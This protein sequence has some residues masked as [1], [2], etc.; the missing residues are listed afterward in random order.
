MTTSTIL[1]NLVPIKFKVQN[2][3]SSFDK[4]NNVK[5]IQNTIPALLVQSECE[6][7]DAQYATDNADIANYGISCRDE[8]SFTG[9]TTNWFAPSID[10][11]KSTSA[12]RALI[13]Q[14]AYYI[15]AHE[16]GEVQIT[17]TPD[18]KTTAGGTKYVI[19]TFDLLDDQWKSRA[20]ELVGFGKDD[21]QSETSS[22]S[23]SDERE[24]KKILAKPICSTPG[25]PIQQSAGGKSQS[26][27]FE[28]G[29]N[30]PLGRPIILET[31]YQTEHE[32]AITAVS[33]WNEGEVIIEARGPINK[34]G[35]WDL[36]EV[37][38]HQKVEE[39]V[40]GNSSE[41]QIEEAETKGK[42]DSLTDFFDEYEDM[43]KSNFIDDS[44]Q[45]NDL[46]MT[47]KQKT[48]KPRL[49]Q[50]QG[51]MQ[52]VIEESEDSD[53][54][55][56]PYQAAKRRVKNTKKKV[57]VGHARQRRRGE[58]EDE[59]PAFKCSKP[60]PHDDMWSYIYRVASD[61][62]DHRIFYRL[63]AE[64]VDVPGVARVMLK[65][66]TDFGLVTSNMRGLR[67]AASS[68]TSFQNFVTNLV[69]L[70][71]TIGTITNQLNQLRF[72]PD[73]DDIYSFLFKLFAYMR[74]TYDYNSNDEIP[75][76][77]II[78]HVSLAFSNNIQL[79][80]FF[81][82]V[83]K[84]QLLNTPNFELDVMADIIRSYLD[85][86]A[87]FQRSQPKKKNVNSMEMFVRNANHL[88]EHPTG[89]SN[90]HEQD[91]DQ[92]STTKKRKAKK[93]K[94]KPDKRSQD[95]DSS[96]N[97][98]SQN[99]DKLQDT[100]DKFMEMQI[101]NQKQYINELRL[102]TEDKNNQKWHDSLRQII[103][104]RNQSQNVP[105]FAT[106]TQQ[107]QLHE[108]NPGPH[109]RDE[110]F[111]PRERIEFKRE[112]RSYWIYAVKKNL[113]FYKEI[114]RTL[115]RLNAG[116]LRD[117]ICKTCYGAH[118]SIDHPFRSQRKR[119]ER[120]QFT[121]NDAKLLDDFGREIR[122]IVAELEAG[123]LN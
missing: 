96:R 110:A 87:I 27:R 28:N 50:K 97:T 40:D 57:N 62:S 64:E 38:T 77:K 121:Q 12:I 68:A 6:K 20:I 71:G 41:E 113:A 65:N 10:I 4:Y 66:M 98:I 1:I 9:I 115:Q 47:R 116:S 25:R 107:S 18:G 84:F 55:A 94:A 102:Q 51:R 23:S 74:I 101:S 29:L 16:K 7:Y 43:N 95:N 60:S 31:G 53:K 13:Q 11:K 122:Q 80:R 24:S 54:D 70:T 105:V 118:K 78:H 42:N 8:D 34:K 17:V 45:V 5:K 75:K 111:Y 58:V 103:D 72:E 91:S 2:Y 106:M 92:S 86:Q 56:G 89:D 63:T 61:Y 52:P 22:S 44:Y 30:V 14:G 104:M 90:G 88:S 112:K 83:V 36:Q 37:R 119:E 35:K 114:C 93:G 73:S 120:S 26:V 99:G 100:L 67:M 46:G 15:P 117:R 123:N 39:T 59:T 85:D 32:V 108:P 49:P 69:R 82:E 48:N 81:S 109:L 3:H 33:D 76:D 19:Q 79:R 21:Q